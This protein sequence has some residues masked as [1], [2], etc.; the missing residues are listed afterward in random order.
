MR[1]DIT[2]GFCFLFVIII[3]SCCNNIACDEPPV[4]SIILIV[5]LDSLGSGL[6]YDEFSSI[7]IIKTTYISDQE[8][9]DTLS[10]D[11]W[12]YNKYADNPDYPR[13]DLKLGWEEGEQ[14][15]KYFIDNNKGLEFIL[16][17]VSLKFRD[18]NSRCCSFRVLAFMSF[19]LNG[20]R[21]EISNYNYE[22]LI[23]K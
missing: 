13:Y 21:N 7:F 20:I 11:H 1:K 12:Y 17:D 10:N 19:N 2:I 22:L 5:S 16:D 23:E 6:T 4:G 14:N 18:S 8:I 15:Y 9:I 3:Q